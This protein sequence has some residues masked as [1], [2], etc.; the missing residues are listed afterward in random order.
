MDR[1]EVRIDRILGEQL[2]RLPCKTEKAIRDILFDIADAMNRY[3]PPD[4][5][6]RRDLDRLSFEVE[7]L[8]IHYAIELGARRI[9]LRAV[10]AKISDRAVYLAERRRLAS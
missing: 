1:F 9:T 4:H 2:T 10:T 7:H 3:P 6:A 5:W 8:R